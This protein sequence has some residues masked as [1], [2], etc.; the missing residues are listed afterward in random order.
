MSIFQKIKKLFKAKPP[1]TDVYTPS[2]LDVEPSKN[3][4]PIDRNRMLYDKLKTSFETEFSQWKSKIS[5]CLNYNS[6]AFV[7]DNGT[8]IEFHINSTNGVCEYIYINKV[9]PVFMGEVAKELYL[10]YCRCADKAD[11]KAEQDELD[12][13][14]KVWGIENDPTTI[15]K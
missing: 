12:K 8:N 6:R 15:T 5:Y 1:M 14:C 3:T 7:H 4:L 11:E 2:F 9:G 13:I 10:E